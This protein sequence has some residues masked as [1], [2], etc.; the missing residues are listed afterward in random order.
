MVQQEEDSSWSDM[1]GLKGSHENKGRRAKSLSI[2]SADKFDEAALD[3]HSK[4]QSDGCPKSN[5][6]LEEMTAA[7]QAREKQLL[8]GKFSY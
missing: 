3:Q 6:T 1:S 2:D 8:A 4:P 5:R 7:F